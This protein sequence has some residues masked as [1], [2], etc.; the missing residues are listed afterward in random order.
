MR[1]RL[2]LFASTVLIGVLSGGV[3][4]QEPATD[5]ATETQE[6][7]VEPTI[8]AKTEGF[9]RHEGLITFHTDSR[10]GK[11]WIELPAATGKRGEIAQFIYVESLFTGLG[12][13]PVGLDRG[14]LG[15]SR[16]VTFRRV[17]GR[18]LIEQENLAF[19]ALS[20]NEDERRAVR[21]SFA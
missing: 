6:E 21:Q 15:P 8:A 13:N 11:L 12:S 1:H 20:Q 10:K 7:K 19:R 3:M 5:N 18:V 16:L 14:Q 17:G 9:D 2:S 4:S